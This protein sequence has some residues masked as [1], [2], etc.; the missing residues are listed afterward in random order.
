[1]KRPCV[2]C[3]AGAETRERAGWPA[4]AACRKCHAAENAVTP[5]MKTVA[6]WAPNE[7]PYPQTRLYRTRD[8]VIFSHARHRG[9]QIPCADCHG[10]VSRMEPLKR[11]REVTMQ[12]CVECHQQ[13]KAT[14][15]CNA[16]H[17]L[18]Q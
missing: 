12:A 15:V 5:P 3:H 2:E 8:F 17:D 18:G 10:D 1:M 14:L 4:A 13:R 7:T 16:C 6:A 11:H 9:A